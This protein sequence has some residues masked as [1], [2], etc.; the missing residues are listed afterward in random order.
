MTD[1]DNSNQR[2]LRFIYEHRIKLLRDELRESDTEGKELLVQVTQTAAEVSA[3]NK[4]VALLAGAS[5]AAKAPPGPSALLSQ[6]IDAFTKERVD[7]G[8]WN[9]K[10]KV[11]MTARLSR[12]FEWFGDVPVGSITRDQM[13]GFLNALKCLPK[14]SNKIAALKGLPLSALVKVPGA[15]CIS[16]ATVNLYME[17]VSALFG[18]FANDGGRWGVTGNVAKALNLSNVQDSDRMPFTA[19]D[20]RALFTSHEWLERAFLHSHGYWLQVLGPFTGA[21]INELCQIKL[22]DFQELDGVAVV[23]L[24]PQGTRGKSKSARRS[25]PIHTELLRLGL[26]RHVEKL[27]ASGETYLFPELPEKRDGHGQTASK[28]FG[29]YK[30]RAGID[31]TKVFHSWRHN[32]A[33]Q[34]ADAGADTHTV[35]GPLLGHAGTT[36]TTRVY[37]HGSI[38]PLAAAIELLSYPVISELVPCV[39]E[40]RF[41]TDIHRSMRRPPPRKS[42]PALVKR[43]LPKRTP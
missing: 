29:K 1:S 27:R 26:L 31:R 15:D 37:V 5:T 36:I 40:I 28:W 35:T 12:V 30:T 20:M 42:A 3:L 41:G 33:S 25:V 16:R 24:C 22:E 7:A 21:R 17:A 11:M 39:E 19:D 8:G 10:T 14:N 9:E 18:W 32:V 38:K 34:L 23:S 43:R 4:V 6:G 13:G 2:V